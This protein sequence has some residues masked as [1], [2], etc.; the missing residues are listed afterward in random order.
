MLH[1]HPSAL[2]YSLIALYFH[3]VFGI[4]AVARLGS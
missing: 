2:D 1:L 4:G 3:C